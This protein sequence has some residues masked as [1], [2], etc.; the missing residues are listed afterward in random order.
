MKMG[1]LTEVANVIIEILVFYNY[2]SK[3]FE[4]KSKAHLVVGYA[5]SAVMLSIV[6]IHLPTPLALVSMT[7]SIIFLSSILCF[8]G[9]LRYKIFYSVLMMVIIFTAESVLVGLLTLMNFGEPVEFLNFGMGRIIGMIGTN[10]LYFWFTIYVYR[11]LKRKVKELPAAYWIMIIL[12]P[13]IS[14]LIL[15]VVFSFVTDSVDTQHIITAILTVGG[16]LYL[17]FSVFNA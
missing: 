3:L 13:I 8:N 17:N 4:Y 12:M 16:L 9:K 11:V 10:L 1:S 6:S 7:F 2:L 14:V 15:S 5:I